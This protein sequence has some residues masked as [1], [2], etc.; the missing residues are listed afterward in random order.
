MPRLEGKKEQKFISTC[1]F[2]AVVI[3]KSRRR[4]LCINITSMISNVSW[5]FF[6]EFVCPVT[7]KMKTLLFEAKWTPKTLQACTSSLLCLNTLRTLIP[8]ALLNFQQIQFGV[9]WKN[10]FSVIFIS[11]LSL[12]IQVNVLLNWTAVDSNWR[13]DNLFWTRLK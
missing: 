1:W 9:Q 8:K 11:R 13:F 5:K 6:G 2:K 10:N 12:I 4:D 7:T 3:K